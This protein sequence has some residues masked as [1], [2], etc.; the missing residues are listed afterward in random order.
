MNYIWYKD[1][2]FTLKESVYIKRPTK[3]LFN[4]LNLHLNDN[5]YEFFNSENELIVFN[6]AIKF[7][8]GND[9]LLINK[10]Y[11]QSN[12]M[13]NDLDIIWLVLG[14]KEVIGESTII[15]EG[16]INSIFYL[17]EESEIVGDFKL[18]TYKPT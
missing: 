17:N 4:L 12:L 1:R 2:D 8:E 14:S 16:N 3:Y 6:P 11:L 15:N 5:E 9:C 13:E 10:E 18:V 7:N